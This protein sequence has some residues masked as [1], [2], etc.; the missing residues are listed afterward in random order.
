VERGRKR[1]DGWLA[2]VCASR[3]CNGMA[4]MTYAAAMPVLKDEWGMTGAQAGTVA[5]GF[6]IGYAVSLVV[7]SGLSDRI[8]P[9]AIYLWSMF[10]AGLS[11]LAFAL[12]ARDFASAVILNTAVGVSLGGTYTTGL[13]ILA[14]RYPSRTRGMAVGYFIASTSCGYACS[15]LISGAAIPV[16]GY[17]LAFLLTGLGPA[18]G[19]A[20]AAI[21]LRAT[22]VVAAGRRPGRR[23]TREVLANRPAMLLIGGYTCHNWELQGMWAWTPAFMAACLGMAG[24]GRVDAAGSGAYV[25]ALFHVVGLLASFSM[26]ALSDRLD[27]ARVMAALAAA[28]MACSFAFGWMADWPIALVIA[29]GMIYAFT[30]LGDSPI[31]SAALSESVH[32]AYLGA[33]LGLRSLIGFGAAALAPVVFG[34]VLDHTNPP[35]GGGRGYAV[36][37]WAYSVLGVGGLGAVWAAWRFGRVRPAAIAPTRGPADPEPRPAPR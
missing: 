37:G 19:W 5:S 28:S 31:L 20:L 34:L 12:L 23:F 33:A 36:W 15:L 3:V 14:G 22:P 13:M 17:R 6:Q 16:G 25:S 32:A 7:C 30:A 2:G 24:A 1:F 21:T 10:A 9:K 26:G 27:R 35:G 4:F 18:L 29:A 11:A 8:S